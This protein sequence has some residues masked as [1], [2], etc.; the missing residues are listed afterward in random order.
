M[1]RKLGCLAILILLSIYCVCSYA[2]QLEQDSWVNI[3]LLGGDSRSLGDY[4][5]TDAM[6]ILSI[7]TKS[8]EVKITSI[9]RDTWVAFPGL[10]ESGKI[11]AANVYGGL[12]LAMQT[13]NECFGMEIEDYVLINMSGL[14]RIID[15]AGGVNIDVA[16][17]ELEY[18]NSYARAFIE[19]TLQGGIYDGETHLDQ[20]GENIHLNGLLAMSYTRNRYTDSDYG[21]VMRQQKVLIAL[22]HQFKDMGVTKFLKLFPDIENCFETSL[23][24]SDMVYLAKKCDDIELSSIEQYR[25]PA[26]GTF[27]S[28]MLHGT[29]SIRPNF[30]QNAELLHEFIYGD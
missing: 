29:W 25:I 22:A 11:N 13:V 28:G 8:A 2:E 17:D 14:V 23:N 10:R 18:V 4:G 21:R 1:L 9:M 24:R 6:V 26:D 16:Q 3:L 7:N 15:L 20:V 27:D 30:D 5:R 19:S 12:E